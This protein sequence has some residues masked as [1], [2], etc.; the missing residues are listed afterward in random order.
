MKKRFSTIKCEADF[1]S[2][3]L[4]DLIVLLN[5]SLGFKACNQGSQCKMCCLGGAMVQCSGS[6]GHSICKDL[7]SSPT[8]DQWNFHL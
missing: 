8:Y 5:V 1:E 3:K 2:T 6:N 4:G 7:G